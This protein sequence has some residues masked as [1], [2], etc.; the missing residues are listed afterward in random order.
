MSIKWFCVF[1]GYLA[2]VRGPQA[3][4]MKV[5]LLGGIWGEAPHPHASINV[6]LAIPAYLLEHHFH[7]NL[8]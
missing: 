1:D 6:V 5:Y 2:R 8:I 3:P 4:D 7:A